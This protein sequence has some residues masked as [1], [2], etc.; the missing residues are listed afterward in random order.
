MRTASLAF[1]AVM[2]FLVGNIAGSLQLVKGY[3]ASTVEVVSWFAALAFGV[4]AAFEAFLSIVKAS[5]P[6]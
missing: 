5:R 6:S 4:W 3:S 2:C 1:F